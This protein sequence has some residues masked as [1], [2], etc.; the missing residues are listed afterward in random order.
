[1][2]TVLSVFKAPVDPDFTYM[3][4]LGED[5]TGERDNVLS[6]EEKVGPISILLA[7]MLVFPE[8]KDKFIPPVAHILKTPSKVIVK[9]QKFY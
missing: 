2:S 5:R 4:G 8:G 1:M 3:L 6:I 9:K 7:D